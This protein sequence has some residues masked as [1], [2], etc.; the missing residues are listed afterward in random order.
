[1]AMSM[2]IRQMRQQ[3]TGELTPSQAAMGKRLEWEGPCSVADL[4]RAEKVKHQSMLATVNAAETAGVVERRPH[5]TDR[6]QVLIAL[7][8]QGRRLLEERWQTGS[9]HL[10]QLM[11]ERLTPDEQQTIVEAAALLRRLSES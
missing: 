5:P 4:A 1:M 6:R 10:A 9:D 3:F 7:T 11:T 2:L 8:D